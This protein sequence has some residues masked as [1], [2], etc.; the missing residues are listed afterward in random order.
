MISVQKKLANSL[1]VLMKLQNQ[2]GLAVIKSS[3][4]SRT[5][6]ERLVSHGFLQEVMRGWY[7]SSRPDSLPGDTTNWYTSY[8]YFISEYATSRFGSDWSLSPEQSLS[9]YSGN[10]VVPEQIIIRSP[11]ASNNT[12]QL[13]HNTQLLDIKASAATTV[14][15]EPQ[16]GLNLYS[17]SESL[18]ECSPDYYRLDSVTARTCLAMVQ[19]V[20]DILKLLTDRGQTTKGA[21]LSG[22]FRNIGNSDAANEIVNTMKGLGYDIR[23]E[24]PFVEQIKL[25]NLS[26]QSPYVIRLRLMWKKMRE[27]VVKCFPKANSLHHDVEK[28]LKEIESQYQLDAYHSLSIE[29]F[30]VTDNLIEKVKKGGWK[31]DIDLTDA[32]QFNALAAR[33]YWQ[34]FQVVKESVRKILKGDNPGDV[35][36]NDHRIWYNELFSPSVTAG[37][38][39]PSD[40]VGYRSNQVFIRGSMHTPFSPEAVRDTIPTLFELLKNEPEASVRAVLGHFVFVYIHPYMDGNGRIARFL[41]NTM[42]ISGGYDWTIIHVDKRRQYMEALEQASVY[43]NIQPFAEFIAEAVRK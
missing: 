4:I 30:K 5:H 40:L 26:S 19:D 34:S 14:Y 38:L 36:D 43:E 35:V 20:S 11:K 16:F 33:G 18:I 25:T 24:D 2:D 10:K 39:K 21:R 15:K 22:A 17:L 41:M 9:F 31:P 6:L 42:L 37:L 1:S 8:W 13:M 23:E 32:E 3:E 27:V 28:Y 7:I 29:G 12:V